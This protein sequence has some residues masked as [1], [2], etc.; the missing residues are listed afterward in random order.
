M[1]ITKPLTPEY[2][3]KMK[4]YAQ[5]LFPELRKQQTPPQ[6]QQLEVSQ[7]TPSSVPSH[8]E[9]DASLTAFSQTYHEIRQYADIATTQEDTMVDEAIIPP[10][11]KLLEMIPNMHITEQLLL[12]NSRFIFASAEGLH[13]TRLFNNKLAIG[14]IY[15]HGDK[16]LAVTFHRTF[17]KKVKE[18]LFLTIHFSPTGDITGGLVAIGEKNQE[19][20][21]VK[22][23]FT[24][25]NQGKIIPQ[26][27]ETNTA[28]TSIDFPHIIAAMTDPQRQNERFD[29]PS[30][31]AA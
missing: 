13:I 6:Q 25:N 14:I 28:I 8:E 20:E 29:L 30:L 10:V 26:E 7:N 2:F 21:D 17:P 5:N 18:A 11:T 23:V 31:L 1:G 19:I 24:F 3:L 12:E 22:E 4:V 9:D 15:P 16:P 27:R